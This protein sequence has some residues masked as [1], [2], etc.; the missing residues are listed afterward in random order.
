ML[1]KLREQSPLIVCITN[2]VVKP[3]TANSLLALGASPIMSSEKKEADDIM[4]H[5]GALLLNIGTCSEDKIPL[6]TE[7][8]ARANQYN[9]P[10][11]LDPVGYGASEFRKDLTD[12]LIR[13]Y[14]IALVKGN[15][16]E[17]QALG[18]QEGASKGVDSIFKGNVLKIA[19]AAEKLLK[20]PVLVTGE[21][22]A[23]VSSSEKLT[24]H[25]GHS[26][27]EKITGS[28]CVLGAITA[29]F[30]A[31][32]NSS[33]SI[34][35]AVSLYNIAAKRAALKANGPG[36]FAASLIDEIYLF[37]AE[38]DKEKRVMHYE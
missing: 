18:G 33:K 29:A 10:I 19:E 11:V 31:V 20:V 21:T 32:N 4:K 22:D 3:F 34:V 23:F 38:D 13:N 28:G 12:T 17:I 5:A 15:A 14:D 27:Q 1:K 2:D 37:K 36:T 26:F 30:L 8:A 16:G 9:V 24:M 6:Y 35:H 25:N 7:M